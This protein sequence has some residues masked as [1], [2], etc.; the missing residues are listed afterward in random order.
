V[1][2]KWSLVAVDERNEPMEGEE[3]EPCGEAQLV[4]YLRRTNSCNNATIAMS[5]FLKAK[6]AGWFIIVANPDTKEVIC[7][8]RV[9]FKRMT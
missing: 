1:E 5:N 8:K 3:L 9:T 2:M 7:L 4:V 6:E